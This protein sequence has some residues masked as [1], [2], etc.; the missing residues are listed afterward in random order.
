MMIEIKCDNDIYVYP[1]DITEIELEEEIKALKNF[2]NIIELRTP[3]PQHIRSFNGAAAT[4][5]GE[6]Y[7]AK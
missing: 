6:K 2:Y 7:A 1:E 5:K 3:L 4:G